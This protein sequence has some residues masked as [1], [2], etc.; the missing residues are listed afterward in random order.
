MFNV[1]YSYFEQAAELGDLDGKYNF[2]YY[3][4]KSASLQNK[5]EEYYRAANLFREVINDDSNYS[6]AHYYMGFM[7]ENGLGIDK[8]YK[9]AL[10]YY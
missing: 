4:L 7:F 10:R 2:A 8:D 1:F 3:L 6:D 9:T 5:E